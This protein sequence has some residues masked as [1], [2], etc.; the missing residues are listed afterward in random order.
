MSAVDEHGQPD[1]LRPAEVDERVHGGADR[2]PGV[3]HVVDEDDRP[4]VDPGR[5][6]RALDNRLLSDEREV[7]AVERDVER[8]DRHLGA[9]VLEDRGSDPSCQRHATALDADEQ[10]PVGARLLLD[11]LV[12]QA[13]RRATNL[14]RGHDP[15][16]A[17]RSF[18]ASLGH[19]G[20]LTG[21]RPKGQCE[22]YR[23]TRTF[24]TRTP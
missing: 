20:G 24:S 9:L 23:G 12:R 11:D 22:G 14:V 18:P 21:P 7:V 2:P 17:H 19:T 5:Q 10:Q 15:A 8:P 3:Q 4:P 13:D 16:S 6:L 1:R